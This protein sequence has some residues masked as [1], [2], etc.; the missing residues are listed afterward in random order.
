M[1]PSRRM[2]EGLLKDKNSGTLEE[3]SK[4]TFSKVKKKL[5]YT[6]ITRK[7]WPMY[8]KSYKLTNDI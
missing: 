4:L 1:S 8:K 5:Q 6:K 7:I 3:V 2:E